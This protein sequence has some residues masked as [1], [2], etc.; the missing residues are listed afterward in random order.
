MFESYSACFEFNSF[1][2][3]NQNNEKSIYDWKYFKNK[4]SH[5]IKS[6]KPE[7]MKRNY[8]TAFGQ[9][10][11]DYSRFG[12]VVDNYYR[13]KLNGNEFKIPFSSKLPDS[14]ETSEENKR[15][16]DLKEDLKEEINKDDSNHNE[17]DVGIDIVFEEKGKEKDVELEE[18]EVNENQED[19]NMDDLFDY[20]NFKYEI[21]NK[22]N[23]IETMMRE[24]HLENPLFYVKNRYVE[25]LY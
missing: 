5:F 25:T 16:E 10:T 17:N 12:E 24:I 22:F 19:V 14:Y 11:Y 20:N 6:E 8:D 2:S 1:D 9:E 4:Y 18:G 3:S 23:L 21:D 7:S 13:F 15:G